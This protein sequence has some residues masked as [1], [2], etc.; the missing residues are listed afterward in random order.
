[1]QIPGIYIMAN[2]SHSTLYIGASSVLPVRIQMHVDGEGSRFTA[3][4]RCTKLVYYEILET[5]DGAY[6]R[7]RE[8]KKWSRMKKAALIGIRNPEWGDM[9]P[10]LERD[11]AKLF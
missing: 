10:E 8:L 5:V 11:V 9:L 7:E 4:Y 1:M 6:R 2:S 3:K